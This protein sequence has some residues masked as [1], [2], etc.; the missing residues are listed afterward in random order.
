MIDGQP[1]VPLRKYGQRI[2]E[3]E[4]I[5]GGELPDFDRKPS[6]NMCC[7]NH[8]SSRRVAGVASRLE[9]GMR[10]QDIVGGDAL[11]VNLVGIGVEAE[12]LP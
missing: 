2:G 6:S 8:S 10:L 4:I 3:D 9:T 5:V 1:Q 12:A 11:T 7:S